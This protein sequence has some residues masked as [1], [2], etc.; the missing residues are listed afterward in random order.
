VSG[1]ITDDGADLMRYVEGENFYFR[2]NCPGRSTSW[3]G[4]LEE[5]IYRPA[6]SVN[7]KEKFAFLWWVVVIQL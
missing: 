3:G 4:N 2:N 5:R 1:G 6:T 7:L